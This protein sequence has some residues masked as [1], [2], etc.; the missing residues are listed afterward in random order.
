MQRKKRIII[1]GTNP[2]NLRFPWRNTPF[3]GKLMKNNL[4][5]SQ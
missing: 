1:Q 5:L 3:V 2:G 4:L